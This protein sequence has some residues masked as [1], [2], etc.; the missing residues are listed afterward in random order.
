MTFDHS[1]FDIC[2]FDISVIAFI[3]HWHLSCSYL[4]FLSWHLTLFMLDS[5]LEDWALAMAFLHN[6]VILYNEQTTKLWLQYLWYTFFSP[7]FLQLQPTVSR[8]INSMYECLCEWAGHWHQEK[9][10]CHK[11]RNL[12]NFRLSFIIIFFC[13]FFLL[14]FFAFCCSIKCMLDISLENYN[15]KTKNKKAKTF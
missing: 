9:S 3:W 1:N 10:L 13:F 4:T 8:Q 14:L 7:Q 11:L 12:A 2:H 5:I 15:K 6:F